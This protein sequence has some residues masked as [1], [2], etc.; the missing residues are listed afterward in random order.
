[1]CVKTK[2]QGSLSVV[3][4]SSNML[5]LE[6]CSNLDRASRRLSTLDCT[7]RCKRRLCKALGIV[8]RDL[9][10]PRAGYIASKRPNN[11]KELPQAGRKGQN[12]SNPASLAARGH[13]F[14]IF[15]FP[16]HSHSHPIDPFVSNFSQPHPIFLL[17]ANSSSLLFHLRPILPLQQPT[18]HGLRSSHGRRLRHLRH[19][20]GRSPSPRQRKAR[21]AHRNRLDHARRHRRCSNEWHHA[22]SALVRCARKAIC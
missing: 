19:N 7:A 16:F 6:D 3:P 17:I 8:G 15:P 11:N 12:T 13:S 20:H 18:H 2:L 9:S 4:S 14:R 10:S 21:R 5:E 22:E 1:M